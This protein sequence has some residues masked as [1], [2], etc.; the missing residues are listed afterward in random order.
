MVKQKISATVDPQRLATAQA[1]SGAASVS[2][3]IDAALRALI[4]R[5]LEE[6]WLTAHRDQPEDDLPSEVTP[7]LADVPWES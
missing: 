2:A 1:L 6:R 3:V 7:D 4:D 5:E